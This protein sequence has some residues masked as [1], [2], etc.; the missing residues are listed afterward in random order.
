MAS[1]RRRRGRSSNGTG[2]IHKRSANSYEVKYSYKDATGTSKRKSKYFKTRAEAESFRLEIANEIRSGNYKDAGSLTVG[3]WCKFWFET[4]NNN[5]RPSTKSNYEGYINNQ[6]IPHIGEKKLENLSVNDLQ[7]FFNT[8]KVHGNTKSD[9]PLSDKTVKNIYRMLHCCL[10]QAVTNDLIRKNFCDGIE[11]PSQDI[12]EEARVLNK[13]ER[14][15][16]IYALD[17]CNALIT[18]KNEH[19]RREKISIRYDVDSLGYRYAVYTALYTGARIG[20]V[21]ALQWKDIDF[22]N[23]TICI[24][25]S[26]GR[27][28][29]YSENPKSKTVLAVGDTKTDDSRR[30]VPMAA[31]LKE[32]LL[33]HKSS[34]AELINDLSDTF[35]NEGYVFANISGKPVESRTIQDFFKKILKLADVADG[36]FHCLRHT[37]TTKWMESQRDV[38][39]LSAIL[40]HSS[41][42]KL[43]LEVYAHALEEHKAEQMLGFDY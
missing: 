16:L 8:I 18:S 11:L 35:V 23:N 40:G 42:T 19:Y 17:N 27:Y 36:N 3:G 38:K 30:F 41:A 15:K 39:T 25:K 31:K 10:E 21:M 12:K 34:Q 5:I 2:T 1:A 22:D 28:K 24:R 32:K 43:T 29:D 9:A 20:E 26:L 14:E 4:Y 37:F 33:E 13:E 7:V 6:I